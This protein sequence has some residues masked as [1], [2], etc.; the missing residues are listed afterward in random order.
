MRGFEGLDFVGAG[1]LGGF[2]LAQ[3]VGRTCIGVRAGGEQGVNRQAEEHKWRGFEGRDF[4]GAGLL[5]GSALA[6]GAGR[7]CSGRAGSEH[8]VNRQTEEHNCFGSGSWR[9]L[10]VVQGVGRDGLNSL[11]SVMYSAGLCELCRAHHSERMD[12]C[13]DTCT[14]AAA[15][16]EALK[17]RSHRGRVMCDRTGPS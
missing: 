4:V 9:N 2:A 1:L 7:T 5:G 14:P 8:G 17:R 13:E 11:K 10:Q 6:R 15:S 3:G 16:L 12:A